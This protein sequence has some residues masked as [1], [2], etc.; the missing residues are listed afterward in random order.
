VISYTVFDPDDGSG[1]TYWWYREAMVYVH[2]DGREVD[3]FEVEHP[4][5]AS[6][7][8]DEVRAAVEA[9]HQQR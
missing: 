6:P 3:A 5:G 1:R 8:F 9:R 4:D 7:S 2:Q